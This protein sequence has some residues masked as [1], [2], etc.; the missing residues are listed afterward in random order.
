MFN[1][2]INIIYVIASAVILA[3]FVYMIVLT[4]KQRKA[5]AS[6]QYSLD[7]LKKAYDD[8][9]EQAKVIVKKD[10]ELNK[11]QEEL[12]KKLN[13]LYT[14]HKL[15]KAISAT[16]D[17]ENLFSQID[18]SFISELGFDRGLIILATK[19]TRQP[20][21]S[22]SVGYSAGEQ[23]KI[24]GYL[25][26]KNIIDKVSQPQL[27]D[28]GLTRDPLRKQLLE[29]FNLNAFCVV[30][31]ISQE[32]RLGL[33]VVG[34]DTPYARLTEGDLEILSV[35][36]GQ[37]ASGVENAR[38]YEELWQSHQQLEQ[39]VTQRTK[40]L[41]L[42]NE[43]LK[44]IDRLKSEFVS[45]V[46][47]ELRTPLTSIK[48]YAAILMAEKL[49][50]LPA[51]VKERLKKINKHSDSLTKLV[52]DLLD[53]SRIESGKVGMDL[54]RLNLKEALDEVIDIM[55]PQ[56]KAKKIQLTID[57]PKSIPD[58]S[59]DRVQIRRVFTNL[60]DNAVKF[61][62]EKGNIS[63][64]IKEIKGFLQID[65]RDSGIGIAGN[66]LANIFEEFYREDNP[67]NQQIKGTG[68]GLSLVRRIV[69]AHNGK[70]WAKSTPGKGTTFSFALPKV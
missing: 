21:L 44:R 62:P 26:E 67:V 36:A 4:E 33:I 61:T 68:L 28:G 60:L 16:F 25:S 70:I 64:K 30:P 27:V 59:A 35:L 57:I 7:K 5:R 22:V 69:E 42:A 24:K 32:A 52:N 56:M 14:L 55:V 65:I 43:K 19:D 6:L 29:L 2:H 46:S 1:I 66:A 63:V 10:L 50:V 41:A 12:D 8:L 18:R 38:L 49:G 58:S 3:A 11:T 54:E 51:A 17:M 53:I 47:H 9:D 23:E 13:G 20:A 34:N 31:I 39:R 45:A 48:G 15:T 40:E 37:I